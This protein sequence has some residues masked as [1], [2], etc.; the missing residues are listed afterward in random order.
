MN[1]LIYA[2]DGKMTKAFIRG[3]H[4]KFD[5]DLAEWAWGTYEL[6]GLMSEVNKC[7]E[8]SILNYHW[9]NYRLRNEKDLRNII[10]LK[11][12][13]QNI[14]RNLRDSCKDP[15]TCLANRIYRYDDALRSILNYYRSIAELSNE[16]LAKLSLAAYR[17]GLVNIG[18][19][20][21]NKILMSNYIDTAYLTFISMLNPQWWPLHLTVDTGILKFLNWLL[22]L[23]DNHYL[24]MMVNFDHNYVISDINVNINGSRLIN[25]N[26]YDSLEQGEEHVTYHVVSR[27]GH[28]VLFIG[29]WGDYAVNVT[30]N[31]YF[32]EGSVKGRFID[33]SIRQW[34]PHIVLPHDYL[35]IKY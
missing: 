18:F 17:Y 19:E 35:S 23:F 30:L 14:R 1:I 3:L 33:V 9:I 28:G 31:Y 29:N 7:P 13:L 34:I 8:S 21:L 22:I 32:N 16:E 12:K 20:I 4:I 2:S 10:E 11:N 6:M 5:C 25:D 15:L 27:S 26:Y 24:I